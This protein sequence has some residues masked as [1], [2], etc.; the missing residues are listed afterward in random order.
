MKIKMVTKDAKEKFLLQLA[1]INTDIRINNLE[2]QV[3]MQVLS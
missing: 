1:A 3:I 2:K